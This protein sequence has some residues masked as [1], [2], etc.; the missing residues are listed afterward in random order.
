MIL[1]P[2]TRCS[3]SQ[4]PSAQCTCSSAQSFQAPPRHR[5]PRLLALARNADEDP[6][7]CTAQSPPQQAAPRV[8]ATRPH[9]QVLR[10]R[11]TAPRLIRRPQHS[12]QAAR[13]FLRRALCARAPEAAALTALQQCRSSRSMW[14][15]DS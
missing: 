1:C 7:I 4:P 13:R 14:T 10:F 8:E 2:P 5:P 9:Q 12:V 3:V 11:R 6:A 15:P